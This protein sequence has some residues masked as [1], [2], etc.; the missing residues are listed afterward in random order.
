MK[1][2]SVAAR[3]TLAIGALAVL[4]FALAAW[5]ITR[6]VGSVQEAS[7]R[8]ELAALAHREAEAVG[9]SLENHMAQVRGMAAAA[10]VEAGLPR[11]SRERLRQ[12]VE[13][14]IARDAEAL[15]YWFEMAPDG[16][17]GRDREF[18]GSREGDYADAKG[19]ISIYF[20]RGSDGVA[21]L[22]PANDGEDVLAAEYYTAPRD[23]DGE[24][25]VEP[26]LYPVDGVDVLMTSLGL[27]V[28]REGRFIGVAGADVSLTAIQQRLAANRPYGSGVIRL[29]SQGGNLLAGPETDHITKA[30][31]HPEREAILAAAGRGEVFFSR[32]EDA[33]AG[34]LALQVFVPFRIGQDTGPPAVLMVSAP[35]SVVL[36]GV[37]EV[38]NRVLLIGFVSALALA[39]AVR[40]IL[41]RLVK[42]PLAQTVV[43]V[44][45]LAQGR[46]DHPIAGSGE[47]EVG[48]VANALRK[49]QRDLGARIEEERRVAAINLRVRRALDGAAAGVM[50]ADASGT[51]VYANEAARRSLGEM[52]AAIQAGVPGFDPLAPEGQS[53]YRLHPEAEAVAGDAAVRV[54]ELRFGPYHVQLALAALRDEQGRLAGLVANWTDRT[55]EV[56]TEQ[57]VNA[58]VSA[59]SEGRLDG[60]IAL[61]GKQGFFL[62][63]GTALNRLLDATATGVAEV[64]RV[65]AA[66]AA[67]DL[68]VRSNA[69]LHGVFA[70]MR[71]DANATA[72]AL[73]EVLS[74]IKIAVEQIHTA[75]D[76]IAAGNADLSARTEQQAA[77]LEE[78]AASVEE[79][80]ASVRE[81][82][83]SARTGRE[84][85]A[86]AA[87]VAGRGAEEIQQVITSMQGIAEGA[88]QIESIITTIDGI[89][90]QTNILALNA[91]VEAARAGEQGRGFAVVA[92]EVRALA[93]RSAAS[94]REI[95]AL[96]QQSN[97][98][99]DE[100]AQ[101]VDAAGRTMQDTEAAIRKVNGLMQ[102][103]AEASA[104]QAAGISQ[105]SQ[106]ITQMDSATQQN[107]ALV[108][109]ATAAAKAMADQAAALA[110]LTARFVLRD[111]ATAAR[112]PALVD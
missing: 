2:H 75:S 58:L 33:A 50:I 82:A 91:A 10:E 15:G 23:R 60:R 43:D 76:E 42:R 94:A 20:A 4:A 24:V 88:R 38:R 64:Q 90:F 48:Q 30:L 18:L 99:V 9:R 78:T 109:E 5:L 11:P 79:L 1:L 112:Q 81:N 6:S 8:R 89:A 49:M 108:E 66:L 93:Q 63:L 35:E 77:N 110:E 40:F 27:P 36:A 32:Q 87:D 98:R 46:L 67:G 102:L 74:Q 80:T 16:F 107:A 31:A 52:A 19:R 105:V 56:R 57:E 54:A 73:E 41:V 44:S 101:V 45:A 12:L 70:Q 97:R 22:Q 72:D 47:D 62:Q 25:M 37:R 84:V 111:D 100:G 13:R 51:L 61:A 29:I 69:P 21:R 95:K 104:E 86:Q 103:I 28:K 71:D 26:Y 3:T 7:A 59:A 68:T 17:D 53:L 92:A 55:E 96:I 83:D 14:N 39:F 65:L 34:G 106:T 85:A